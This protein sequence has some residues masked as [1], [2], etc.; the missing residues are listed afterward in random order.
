M[1]VKRDISVISMN[2]RHFFSDSLSSLELSLSTLQYPLL[3][4]RVYYIQCREYEKSKYVKIIVSSM[5][6]WTWLSFPNLPT[7][8]YISEFSYSFSMH[9][10]QVLVVFSGRDGKYVLI[11]YYLEPEPVFPFPCVCTTTFTPW[12]YTQPTSQL[13]FLQRIKYK[14]WSYP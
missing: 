4:F 2:V 9:F 10:S 8:I 5:I 14:C 7:A 13:P 3:G 12:T 6:F 11:L 1:K